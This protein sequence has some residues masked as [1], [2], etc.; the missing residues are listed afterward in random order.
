MGKTNLISLGALFILLGVGKPSPEDPAEGDA[1]CL[2]TADLKMG[3]YEGREKTVS[4][5]ATRQACEA[6]SRHLSHKVPHFRSGSGA[7]NK[8]P[9]LHRA[10]P[11]L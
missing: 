8:S 4:N 2:E 5:R 3:T 10:V 6:L 11:C 9:L 7:P 1:P